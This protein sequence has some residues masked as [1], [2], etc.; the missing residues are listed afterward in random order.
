MNLGAS[1]ARLVAGTNV[2]AIHALNVAHT[3]ANFVF[4]GSLGIA[5]ASPVTL[6]NVTDTW[7]YFPGVVEPTGGLYDP[8][9]LFEVADCRC[10]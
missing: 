5:G 8:A 6:V 2:I 7:Q 1:N 10:R 9:L 4:S 3:N